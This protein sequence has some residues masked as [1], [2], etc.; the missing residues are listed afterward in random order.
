MMNRKRPWMAL[1]MLTMIIGASCSSSVPSDP[2][3][4]NW[5]EKSDFEGAIRSGAVSFSI[6]D[7]GFVGT[8]YDGDERLN[9]FWQY[10]PDRDAWRRISD[11]PGVARSGAVAF[12]ADGKGYVGSGYDGSE[13]LSDFWSYDPLTDRWEQVADLAG[14]ARHSAI[15]FALGN[16]GYV[17]TGFD[18]D[19]DLKDF[20][21]YDP[22]TD[23][24]TQRTSVGG[25]K[26][27]GA[28]SFVVDGTAYVGGGI[29]NDLFETDL[30]KYDPA[31]DRW[32]ELNE[33][34]DDDTGDEELLRAYGV[35][36]AANGK[37]YLATGTGNG[38]L[39]DCWEYNPATDSWVEVTA[40]EGRGREGATAF[41]INGLGYVVTGRNGTSRFDDIW[42][43]DPLEDYE[44]DD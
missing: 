25:S 22:A 27:L 9:D 4:G 15:A 19:N 32:E 38:T 36:F 21:E 44:E 2:D 29:H 40:F 42:H 20:W 17:G 7:M 10:D 5:V 37:A 8:G 33:L 35:A 14:P 30:W 34:D 31:T 28:F 12:V 1:I 26:R 13:E 11:F 6:N 39:A 16:K 24:W 23:A 18:G 3:E 43:F 41:G